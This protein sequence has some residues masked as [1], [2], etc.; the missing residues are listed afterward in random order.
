MSRVSVIIFLSFLLYI[1]TGGTASAGG[2]A[3]CTL[4]TRI[5]YVEG[6]RALKVQE[7][8][9]STRDDCR[10]AAQRSSVNDEPEKI[11][12]KKVS[13]SWRAPGALY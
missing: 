4:T 9:A 5:A 6:G 7:V 8:F 1:F 10:V 3:N 12:L 2:K 11:R 13:F